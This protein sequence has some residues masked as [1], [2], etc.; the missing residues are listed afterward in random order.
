MK[1]KIT[2]SE[3]GKGF[4]YNL[5]LFAKHWWRLADQLK[6]WEE[7]REKS[8]SLFSET[9]CISL[10]F[11]GAGDHFFEF[12][13]PDQWKDH[14]IGILATGLQNTAIEWRMKELGDKKAFDNFFERC[15]ELMMLIDK[16]LGI[17]VEKAQWN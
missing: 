13:I 9:G 4:T 3:F 11:N 16:E 1:K 7:M 2:T 8:P 15:E 17:E 6:T 10:W 5:F 12:K 14:K